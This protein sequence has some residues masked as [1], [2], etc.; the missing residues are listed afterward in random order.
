MFDLLLHWYEM[1]EIYAMLLAWIV[2]PLGFTALFLFM[3]NQF[4]M[5]PSELVHSR[6]D[7]DAQED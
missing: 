5:F 2:V 3:R 6:E 4:G 1:S 7:D